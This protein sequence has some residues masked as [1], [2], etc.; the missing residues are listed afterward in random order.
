M[1]VREQNC[2]HTIE[3][4]NGI[5]KQVKLGLIHVFI[6]EDPEV[7]RGL[8]KGSDWNLCCTDAM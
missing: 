4:Q 1:N 6:D 8:A 5:I 7:H 3:I 2:H